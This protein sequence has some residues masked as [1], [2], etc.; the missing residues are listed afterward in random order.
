MQRYGLFGGLVQRSLAQLWVPAARQPDEHATD[1]RCDAA[2]RVLFAQANG[3]FLRTQFTDELAIVVRGAARLADSSRSEPDW[4]L[5]TIRRHYLRNGELPV[6]H[7][8]GAFTIALLD[9]QAGRVLLY[10]HLVGNGFTYYTQT[11]DGLLFGSNLAQLVDESGLTPRANTAVLPA[12]FLYRFVPGRDTLFESVYRLQPGEQLTCDAAG[13]RRRQRL[14]FADLRERTGGSGSALERVETTMHRIL[15]D[16]QHDGPPT[17]NT[18]SGGVDSS[19]L[20]AVWNR[21]Q[22]TGAPRPRSFGVKVDHPRTLP[23]ADYALSAAAALRVQHTL[24][25]ADGSYVDYLIDSVAT[26]GEPPNHAMSVYF[27]H[28]AR[29]MTAQGFTGGLCGEGADSLFGTA[30]ADRLREARW[31]R[32]LLPFGPLRRAGGLLA[33]L[34]GRDTLPASFALADVIDDVTDP[35][36]LMNQ[37]A[38]FTEGPAV[39]RCFGTDAVAGAFAGRRALL[40]PL[41]V[42]DREA[43]RL[44]AV[45]Y[46][47]EAA[48]SASLWTGMFNAAGAD[49]CCPFLDSRLLSTALALEPYQR[50][51]YRMPKG[52]LKRALARHVPPALAYRA[53][54]GFGQPVFEWLAPGGQLRRWAEGIG[55]HA[56]VPNDVRQ[57][58]LARP[59]WFLYSLLCYDLWHK[60][61]IERSLPRPTADLALADAAM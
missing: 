14:T 50:F 28:L 57:T 39:E 35:R 34:L 37:A 25:P 61:F 32:R 17:A 6:E 13:L 49:L 42:G 47:G 1:W 22:P 11:G 36:H 44:H 52:L 5:D 29:H 58:A 48:D 8:E 30:G 7:L 38:V 41:L 15:A 31:I 40:D 59:G 51:P 20:Q 3:A 53:K 19:Y 46:L 55:R 4:V 16:W 2:E 54:L 43:D 24:V 21:V 12:Y 45:A 9:G 27:G 10:R 56:F 18:L 26:T 33:R 23:D 60:L